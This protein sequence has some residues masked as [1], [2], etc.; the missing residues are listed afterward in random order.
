[1]MKKITKET[2]AVVVACTTVAEEVLDPAI[3]M[4]ED[5]VEASVGNGTITAAPA[6]TKTAATAR[7]QV[8]EEVA[9]HSTQ[10]IEEVVAVA[11]TL[12]EEEA[13]EAT[14]LVAPMRST[15]RW[16]LPLTQRTR[17]V[18]HIVELSADTTTAQAPVASRVRNLQLARITASTPEAAAEAQAATT[19]PKASEEGTKT[20]KAAV[21]R[22]NRE[23]IK[24]RTLSI[25][26]GNST[27]R[28]VVEEGGPAQ[29]V[30]DTGTP[31]SQDRATKDKDKGRVKAK[32]R[33]ARAPAGATRARPKRTNHEQ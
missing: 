15:T 25:S 21:R 6:T 8:A 27:A 11:S 5:E 4:V 2:A 23:H 10:H 17:R 20:L 28:R 32:A 22:T 29:M 24:T 26:P 7:T 12:K 14:V 33:A 1:M 19:T 3:K 30:Q 13:E 31:T 9:N 18:T 16:A